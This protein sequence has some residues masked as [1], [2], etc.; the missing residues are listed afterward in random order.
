MAEIGKHFPW[1]ST[2]AANHK[3]GAFSCNCPADGYA[4]LLAY[5]ICSAGQRELTK[6]ER[7]R[8]KENSG[9]RSP[10]LGDDD[11]GCICQVAG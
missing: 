2:Y 9:E 3:H 10:K 5:L 6:T 8:K 11:K 7:R 1:I 4:H